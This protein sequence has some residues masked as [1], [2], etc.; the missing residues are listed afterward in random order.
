[1]ERTRGIKLSS[2]LSIIVI[3]SV[4]V[5]ILA[6]KTTSIQDKEISS[7]APAVL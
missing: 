1:M 6:A 2:V 7:I 5:G 3:A 4:L